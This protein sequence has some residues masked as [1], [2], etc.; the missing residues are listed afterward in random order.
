MADKR[1]KKSK[2]TSMAPAAIDENTIKGEI[3]VIRGQK[4]M[5]D[6][7]LSRIYGYETKY[8]N[9]QVQR[10]KEK[11]P[12]D[13]MFRLTAEETSGLRCQNGTTSWGGSRYLPYAY[14]EQGIYML[15]TVLKGDSAVRQS[16]TLIRVFKSMK[17]YIAESRE[18]IGSREIL[19]LANETHQNTRDIAEI[20]SSMANKED[21]Q[22]VV[23]SFTDYSSMKHFLILDGERVEADEAY[24]RI[25][26]S[27][28]KSIIV[29]DPYLSLKTLE[30]LR[31]A[32]PVVS[33]III[34]DNLK[35]RDM[36]TKNLLSDFR[37]EYPE[38]NMSFKRLN[39][40]CHDRYVFLDYGSDC[41]VLYHCGASSKD[42]G[43][44]ATTIV[45]VDESSL[46]HP[47]MDSLLLN[48]ELEIS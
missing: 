25:Y 17:D 20:K 26:G 42:A 22:K 48:E 13:F 12:D 33:I 2:V 1:E 18:L 21:L 23:D 38:I 16:I 15:M 3:Y 41:E 8:L 11:F 47:L 6:F 28:K 32:K 24:Q 43:K 34:S 7:D 40:R 36:L 45:R 35:T 30:L 39:G 27:A 14:T 19:R 37:A 4:V 10:N 5:L 46:Y 31:E 44:K 29:I 9:R